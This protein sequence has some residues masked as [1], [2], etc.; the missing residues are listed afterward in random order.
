MK[1]CAFDLYRY[2][3]NRGRVT[4]QSMADPA[5]NIL[6]ICLI[7]HS[8][9]SRLGRYLTSHPDLMNLR[10]NR[11]QYDVIIRAR[12]GLRSQVWQILGIY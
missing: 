6:G 7:G 11:E 10:L 2:G 12:G 9:I 8:F 5:P 1:L 3:L 4:R